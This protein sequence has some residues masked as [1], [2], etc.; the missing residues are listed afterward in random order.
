M[1]Q[2]FF[3]IFDKHVAAKRLTGWGWMAHNLGGYWRRVGFMVAPSQDAVLDAQAAV[4]KDM[5]AQTQAFA[6]LSRICP[7][8]ED[9]I[10]RQ[11]ASSER[12]GQGPAPRSTARMAVYYECAIAR[13]SRV[14]TLVTQA[15]AP[16][17]NQHV[18]ADALNS[19]GWHEHVIGGKYRRLLLLN[20]GNHKALLTAVESILAQTRRE[21]QAEGRE[22]SEICHSHQDYLW[23]IR[24][25]RR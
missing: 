23:D 14:D 24:T 25:P 17:W 3:P 11:V 18:K 2:T 12:E 21:R 13:Q 4:L 9:Y 1:R 6:E 22:F 16:I 5:Q 19:W 7:R 10:W 8:H 20:G 15:L